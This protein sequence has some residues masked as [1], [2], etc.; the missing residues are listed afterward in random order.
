MI[1][2]KATNK[3]NG[4]CYIGQ[5]TEI[6][7]RRMQR[8]LLSKSRLYFHCAIRKYG[9][10]NFN[11]TILE[12]CMSKEDMNDKE[13][14]YIKLFKSNEKEYGYNLTDG[15]TD[16][17][18]TDST[19]KKISEANKIRI[20]KPHTEETKRKISESKKGKKPKRLSYLHTDE[21]KRKISEKKKGSIVTQ[22]TRDKISKSLTGFK[23]PYKKRNKK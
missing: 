19:K 13:K 12:V 3:I 20:Y 23:R 15:G 22:N 11:W 4:K 8:H 2:Y 18:H 21:T 9:E 7:N 1:I 10:E 16:C 6:L 14:Y 17:N 5:T